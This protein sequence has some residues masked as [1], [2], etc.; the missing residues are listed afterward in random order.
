[1]IKV[2]FNSLL[3]KSLLLFPKYHIYI[4]NEEE[5][6]ARVSKL[7]SETL[8]IAGISSTPESIYSQMKKEDLNIDLELESIE[9]ASDARVIRT[10]RRQ[11]IRNITIPTE[12]GLVQAELT[13]TP[14]KEQT[15]ENGT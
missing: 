4:M 11:L 9:K 15:K 1:M 10:I 6:L 12:E 13:F 5:I 7:A 14:K 3:Q 8:A 2:I